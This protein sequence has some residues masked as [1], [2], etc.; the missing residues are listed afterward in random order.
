MDYTFVNYGP[1]PDGTYI[2]E[3][4]NDEGQTCVVYRGYYEHR[5]NRFR[6]YPISTCMPGSRFFS[7]LSIFDRRLK[8]AESGEERSA[9]WLLN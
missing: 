1:K 2:I 7:T 4:V 9:A 8:N 3:Q 5:F 6:L